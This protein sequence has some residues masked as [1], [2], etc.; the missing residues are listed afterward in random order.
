MTVVGS[1]HLP[2]APSDQQVSQEGT[3]IAVSAGSVTARSRDGVTRTYLVTPHTAVITRA[4]SQFTVNDEVA[5]IGTI[6]NG[7]ALATA[8]AHRDL[9]DGAGPPMDYVAGQPDSGALGDD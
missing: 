3:L 8:V 9:G 7:T 2:P 1:P 5:I 6:Q 4:G